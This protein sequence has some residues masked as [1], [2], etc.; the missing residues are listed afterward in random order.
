M[1]YDGHVRE[2]PSAGQLILGTTPRDHFLLELGLLDLR[3]AARFLTLARA[4]PIP[5]IRSGLLFQPFRFG[6]SMNTARNNFC[7]R[8]VNDRN[9]ETSGLKLLLSFHCAIGN[10]V[11][12]LS[13]DYRR[14]N[15]RADLSFLINSR[16]N[17]SISL[18][19]CSAI[20]DSVPGYSKTKESCQIF[21]HT[22]LLFRNRYFCL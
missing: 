13:L 11:K 22:C 9:T 21:F 19:I 6:R 8:N 14:P 16:R 5:P 20:I 15:F 2:M 10:E 17:F 4:A 7:S 12:F 1:R 3:L 18:A